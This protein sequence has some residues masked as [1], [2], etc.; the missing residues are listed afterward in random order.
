MLDAVAVCIQAGGAWHAP[1]SIDA[2]RT[3]WCSALP[4][5]ASI[6]AMT[7]GT[8][9]TGYR[10]V[11]LIDEGLPDGWQWPSCL[12]SPVAVAVVFA[13]SFATWNLAIDCDFRS[14]PVFG[15]S[16]NDVTDDADAI[17]AD[18]LVRVVPVQRH[19]VLVLDGGWI[20][21]PASNCALRRTSHRLKKAMRL[22][23]PGCRLRRTT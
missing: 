17:L 11:D 16:T 14:H 7:N 2:I 1:W 9:A 5:P 15:V 3:D 4:A 20:C 21:V 13:G 23:Y 22:T 18:T 8:G 10:R 12:G 19:R 6:W